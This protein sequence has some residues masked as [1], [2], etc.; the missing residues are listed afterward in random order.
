MI[1]VMVTRRLSLHWLHVRLQS[2]GEREGFLLPLWNPREWGAT[3][4]PGVTTARVWAWG[5]LK[6]VGKV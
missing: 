3:I 5:I 2:F 4:S 1:F 6:V